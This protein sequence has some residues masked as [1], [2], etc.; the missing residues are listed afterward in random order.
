MS[1]Y[2]CH[3]LIYKFK[4]GGENS[5][6]DGRRIE[7]QVR[8]RLQHAWATAV[9]A[10]GL[11]RQEDLKAGKGDA[12]WLRLFELMSAELAMAEDCPQSTHVPGHL[13]RIREIRELNKKL[14]AVNT[15]EDLRH[16]VRGTD[17]LNSGERRN[18]RSAQDSH[19]LRR[20]GQ[21]RRPESR[22]S[23]LLR[24]RAGFQFEPGVGGGWQADQGIHNAAA[25]HRSATPERAGR[26]YVA[27]PRRPPPLGGTAETAEAERLQE[28]MRE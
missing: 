22:I 16:A 26:L 28:T 4:G 19:C 11:M 9:E 5:V 2:R 1:T 20:G 14:N 25:P 10:V 7:I 24:R 3:H 6:F 8:T 21:D 15:L 12:D 23:K 18:Q 13:S 27:A 17:P